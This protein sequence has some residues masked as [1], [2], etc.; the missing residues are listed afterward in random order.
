MCLE[1]VVFFFSLIVCPEVFSL[2]SGLFFLNLSL[3]S[4]PIHIFILGR[5]FVMKLGH[6]GY[7]GVLFMLPALCLEGAF[8]TLSERVCSTFCII[9]EKI[10]VCYKYSKKSTF[11]GS[12]P[13]THASESVN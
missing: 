6:N 13:L 5:C 12:K 10:E 3:I 4:S 8:P 2:T 9:E 7:G 1:S 11:C